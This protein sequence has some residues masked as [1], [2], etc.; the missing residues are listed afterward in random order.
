MSRRFDEILIL[1]SQPDAN[2]RI[3]EV[4]KEKV[5]SRIW[6]PDDP[7]YGELE[8]ITQDVVRDGDA[9]VARSTEELDGVR[10]APEEFRVSQDE[11]QKAH[12]QLSTNLLRSIRQAI[13]NVRKYQS[14]IF[15][16]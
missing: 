11:L 5:R 7:R 12:S 9:A 2:Q 8:T 6:L 4:L 14:E 15:V 16:G 1:S 10:L 13:A 3:D